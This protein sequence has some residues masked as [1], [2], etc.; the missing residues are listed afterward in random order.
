[1]INVVI[2]DDHSIVRTGLAKILHAESDIQIAGEAEGHSQ[3]MTKLRSIVP[4]LVLLDISMPGRNGLEIL[5]DLKHYYSTIKIL[6]LSMYPEDSYAVR[7]IKS[8]A[9]GYVMKESAADEL[10]KAIRTVYHG[11][12]YVTPSLAEKIVNS[13]GQE[14]QPLH[15]TLSDRELQILNLI[16]SGKAVKEIAG[17]LSLSPTTVATYRARVL[18][19]MKLK[20]N[21]ELASYAVRHNLVD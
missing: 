19:K 4:D 13:F 3:L 21:V 6:I 8:G 11:G 20:S 5:K 15:E 9:S 14:N 12:K 1:M 16:A 2:C 17:E 18:E 10:V 7:A